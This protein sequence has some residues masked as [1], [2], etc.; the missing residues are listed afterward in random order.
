MKLLAI[1]TSTEACSA[2]LGID[3]QVFSY[4]ELAPRKHAELILPMVEELLSEAQL[5]FAQLDVLAF[6]RGPGSFTG[7]RIAAGVI[8]GIAFGADLP[9]V[10]VSSL[11]ALAQGASRTHA[12]DKVLAG[13]DARMCEVYWSMYQIDS[14]GL[15][16]LNGKELVCKPDSIPLPDDTGWTGAGSA[17]HEYHGI[18]E[19]RLGGKL[20]G[21]HR[22]CYPQALDIVSLGMDGFRQGMSVSAEDAI[23]VYLRDNVVTLKMN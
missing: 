12:V 20:R 16:R 4:Y 7:L 13:F 15:A 17:W 21:W 3:D 14:T 5:S 23:P 18:L 2:A 1:D 11:A 10:P 19:C 8:Q 6:G 22:N 9:V